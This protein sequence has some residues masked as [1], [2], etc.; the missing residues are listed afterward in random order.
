ML[1]ALFPTYTSPHKG[2]EVDANLEGRPT[3]LVEAMFAKFE[4]GC[5][6]CPF[7]GFRLLSGVRISTRLH[8]YTEP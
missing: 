1:R 7:P 3:R 4:W 6:I 8:V 5:S 2:V